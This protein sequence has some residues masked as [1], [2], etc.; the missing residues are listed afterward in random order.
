M[1]VGR[2]PVREL[3]A[4]LAVFVGVLFAFSSGTHAAGSG[5]TATSESAHA[6]DLAAR[7]CSDCPAGGVDSPRLS[8]SLEVPVSRSSAAIG[9][10]TTPSALVVATNNGSS[11][12]QMNREIQRGQASNGIERVDRADPNIPGSQDHVLFT[13]QRATLNRDGTWGHGDEA[14]DLT[15]KQREW[16]EGHGWCI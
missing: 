6:Y 2:R 15:K 8:W 7:S 4:L 12:N 16:L 13:G 10:S 1:S 14:L 11:P 5:A 9:A 3:L